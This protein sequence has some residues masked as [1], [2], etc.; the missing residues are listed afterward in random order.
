[1]LN[2][3]AAGGAAAP[4]LGPV[5][6]KFG[7]VVP[8]AEGLLEPVN[9]A[10]AAFPVKL[11]VGFGISG[12]IKDDAVGVELELK[13]KP[14]FCEGTDE[15]K[16]LLFPAPKVFAVLPN[17]PAVLPNPADVALNPFSVFPKPL[18]VL[19]GFAN[20]ELPAPEP[21]AV[22]V[23]FSLEDPN[24]KFGFDPNP[25]GVV[26]DAVV[27]VLKAE[28]AAGTLPKAELVADP[29]VG[30][31]ATLAAF[32]E[33]NIVLFGAVAPNIAAEGAPKLVVS[34]FPVPK[35]L[36]DPKGGLVSVPNEGIAA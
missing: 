29:K 36:V 23:L 10:L 4:K 19:F 14:A 27:T 16:A 35:T 9:E 31:G 25:N 18:G 11:K 8:K 12:V 13:L 26:V 21:K 7:A 30:V 33:P 24:E 32:V 15:P 20:A 17:P 34:V 2:T 3:P 22:L 1:M 6:E 28:D 5:A